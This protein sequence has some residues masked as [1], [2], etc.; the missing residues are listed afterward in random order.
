METTSAKVP[1]SFWIVSIIFLLW[2]LMGVMSFYMH[3]FISDEAIA[4]L[5]EA[6]AA[7]YAEYPLWT[8]IAFAVAVIG[9]LLASIGLLMRQ[10]GVR[11]LASISLVAIII[12]MTHNVFFTS[13]MEVYGVAQ[14]VTMPILVVIL[15]ALLLWYAGRAKDRGWLR[16]S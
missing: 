2:N 10:K 11:F 16:K 13:A 4:A 9:G 12:Q 3:V 15:G 7:M 5:P 8:D 14:A 6:E 1:T